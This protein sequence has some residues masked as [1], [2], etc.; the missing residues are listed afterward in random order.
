MLM[1]MPELGLCFVL[2]VPVVSLL[3]AHVYEQLRVAQLFK[4]DR[5]LAA[6]FVWQNNTL[7][8]VEQGA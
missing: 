8:V 4:A 7:M 2:P 3:S 5:L 1:L 6:Q